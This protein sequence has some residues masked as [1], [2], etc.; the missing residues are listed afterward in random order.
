MHNNSAVS[1]RQHIDKNSKRRSYYTEYI[2]VWA[3]INTITITVTI[4]AVIDR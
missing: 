2:V 4:T 1:K 3:I